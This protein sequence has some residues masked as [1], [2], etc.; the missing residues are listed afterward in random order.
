MTYDLN[1]AP[2]RL[3]DLGIDDLR[4]AAHQRHRARTEDWLQS[5][6]HRPLG[7]RI[8]DLFRPTPSCLVRSTPAES[9]SH[10]GAFEARAGH[11]GER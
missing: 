5:R 1:N 7:Q 6:V 2:P 9:T 4:R 11:P 10:A 8:A 3:S